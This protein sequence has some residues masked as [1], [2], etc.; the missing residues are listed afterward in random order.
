M[1]YCIKC[2]VLDEKIYLNLHGKCQ[3]AIYPEDDVKKGI[4]SHLFDVVLYH[5]D[6]AI[7]M[8]RIVGDNRLVFFIKDF[9]ILPEYRGQKLSYL[10]MAS[11]LKY[12]RQNGCEQAYIG[13]MATKGYERF[14]EKFGFIRRPN[15]DLGSGMVMF[16]EK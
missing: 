2:N 9:M 5:D 8:A 14:Y 11:L 16:N 15:K 1:S 6:L 10:I 13:L 12:I 4:E 3:F 7:G